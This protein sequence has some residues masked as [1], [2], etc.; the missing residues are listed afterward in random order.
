MK[1]TVSI[2]VLC[3]LLFSSCMMN[4]TTIGYGP[5]GAS[6]HDR[7][8]S[9]AK[10][11]YVFFGLVRTNNPKTVIPPVGIGYE[12]KTGFSFGDCICSILFPIYAQRTVWILVNNQD[13]KAI[14]DRQNTK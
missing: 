14:K 3:V 2:L 4:R 12:I 9:K 1:K 7:V 10:Q 13:E 5:V 6:I 8:Y 11:H